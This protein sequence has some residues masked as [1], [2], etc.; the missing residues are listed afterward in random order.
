MK[1]VGCFESETQV[2]DA[3]E[4]KAF[5]LMVAVVHPLQAM[6]EPGIAGYLAS[7]E[8]LADIVR[9]QLPCTQGVLDRCG[10]SVGMFVSSWL[11]CLYAHPNLPPSVTT[12][13][14]ELMFR[15]GVEALFVVAVALL[16]LL[17]PRLTAM[18]D[19]V[20]VLT[21][22]KAPPADLLL[23]GMLMQAAGDVRLGDVPSDVARRIQALYEDHGDGWA[24]RSHI[25]TASAEEG[26]SSH[27][28]TETTG[29]GSASDIRH[30]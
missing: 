19:T 4:E 8:I 5:W 11:H 18:Q 22:L 16:T 26:T 20:E 28:G 29:V 9:V 7:V 15:D 25:D 6:W 12:V 23:R 1:L 14:W 3:R 10:L 30:N 27:P 24:N 2:Q 13:A 21:M 17:E